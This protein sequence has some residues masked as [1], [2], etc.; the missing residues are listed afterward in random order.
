MTTPLLGEHKRTITVNNSIT[1]L[2]QSYIIG[3]ETL[4]NHLAFPDWQTSVD[5][6]TL[7]RSDGLKIAYI[8]FLFPNAILLAD[9]P[10]SCR[11]S[12]ADF[13][14]AIYSPATDSIVILAD[15]FCIDVSLFVLVIDI[16]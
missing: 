14:S 7:V 15:L 8:I 11:V 2:T 13:L 16:S 12:V 10:I 6:V 9:F 3:D 5:T 1:S 4:G